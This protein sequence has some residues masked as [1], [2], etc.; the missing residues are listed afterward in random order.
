VRDDPHA[1]QKA[2]L[3]QTERAQSPKQVT[4]LSKNKMEQLQREMTELEGKIAA[5]ESELAEL[6]VSFQNPA[7]GTDWESTH[8]RYADLKVTLECLYQD[9][10]RRWDL[11]G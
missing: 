4:G 10:A 8:R 1:A 6:E 3:S 7:T 2:T 5:V 9:L 11:M